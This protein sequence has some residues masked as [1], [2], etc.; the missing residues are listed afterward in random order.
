MNKL[1]R[2][3]GKRGRITIPYELRRRVGF[4]HNDILSFSEQDER[5]VLIRREKLCDDCAG[6]LNI[7]DGLTLLEFLDSLSAEEQRAVLVHLTV[8]WA[9]RKSGEAD[10]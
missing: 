7:P 9:E 2:I 10:E 5:T 4:T 6:D 3:L 1:Y 8:K